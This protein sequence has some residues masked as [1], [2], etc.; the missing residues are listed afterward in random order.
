VPVNL[1]E[2]VHF[3]IQT[4]TQ[5]LYF[6]L[7]FVEDI[8]AYIEQQRKRPKSIRDLT[9]GMPEPTR[10]EFTSFFKEF[11]KS[12]TGMLEEVTANEGNKAKDKTSRT[13]RLSK[14]YS[15][16]VTDLLFPVLLKVMRP[17]MY[18]QYLYN[19]ALTH[20]ITIFDAFLHDFLAAI[21][22]Q[23]PKTLKSENMASYAEIL[24]FP[25]MKA[26]TEYLADTRVKKIL[27]DNNIDGVASE[28]QKRFTI[29]I[30]S[31]S[32]F[33]VIREAFYR[34]HVVVH[35]KGIADRKYCEKISKSQVGCKLS[36][37]YE[38]L[39]TLFA[40]IGQLVDYLD[41][42]LSRKMRYKRMPEANLLLT[43]PQHRLQSQ[44][45]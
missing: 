41:E 12:M 31:C 32:G 22:R 8:E 39:A 24:S 35:N 4:S 30:S 10:A 38:Y 40:A 1:A 18:P 26:L 15:D 3:V 14:T 42:H 23:R 5:D 27:S 6:L 34:R 9:D 16:Q 21:F 29:D 28:L 7:K 43:D 20:A 2:E 36:T 33:N 37:N 19:M 11:A 17:I 25:S 45:N 13:I 44:D